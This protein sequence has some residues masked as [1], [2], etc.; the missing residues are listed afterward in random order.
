MNEQKQ[1]L[2]KVFCKTG[3]STEPW[4]TPYLNI[5]WL[6]LNPSIEEKCLLSE[7]LNK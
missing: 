6:T 3:L 7:G 5:A 2:K 1:P 4:E